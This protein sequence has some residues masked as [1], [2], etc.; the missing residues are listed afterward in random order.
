[1]ALDKPVCDLR[2]IIIQLLTL[3]ILYF[4]VAAM[5]EVS[6]KDDGFPVGGG[7][8]S[9]STLVMPYGSNG[10]GVWLSGEIHV[11]LS[12]TIGSDFNGV[13]VID[14]RL[15]SEDREQ[16]KHIHG[17]LCKAAVEKP[18]TD[19]GDAGSDF[20]Y[21]VTCR[22]QGE[23]QSYQGRLNELPRELAFTIDSYRRMTLKIYADNGR[24][25]VKLDM[26]VADVQ[27]ERD[28]FS[29]A[30]KFFNSG[31]YPIMMHTPD[32]WS[33]QRRDSLSILGKNADDASEWNIDLAGLP[34]VNKGEFPDD[35]VTVAAGASVTF[36]FLTVPDEKVKRGKYYVNAL[37]VTGIGG[38]GVVS[39]IGRV[40]FHSDNRKP[41]IVTFDRDY[42]STSQEWEDYE[43]RQRDK[44][45]GNPVKPGAVFAEA[46]HYRLVS[47]RGQRSLF[48][49]GFAEGAIAPE[50]TNRVDERGESFYGEVNWQWEADRARETTCGPGEPCPREGRWLAC[51]WNPGRVGVPIRCIASSTSSSR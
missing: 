2:R 31:R 30:V 11:G 21:S 40:S 20:V 23:L 13:G 37:A 51:E 36:R 3:I 41:A 50:P 32:R 22:Q 5:P 35:I 29:I 19:Q 18:K 1:M 38:D 28:K 48:V 24:A 42:P 15:S 17:Q 39:S 47:K 4:G 8:G 14:A 44:L 16:A 49:I 10:V 45:S 25:I 9:T 33:R 26:V 43:S 12:D 46:G 34:L 27:R 6:A 7:F